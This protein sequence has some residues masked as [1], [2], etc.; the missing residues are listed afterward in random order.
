[1]KKKLMI[2][3]FVLWGCSVSSVIAYTFPTQPVE[4]PTYQFRSTSTCLSVVGESAFAPSP[5]Y[6]P[7]SSAQVSRPRR[8]GWDAPD[9]EGGLGIVDTPIGSP[10]VLVV[11]AML[12]VY[13]K[14]KNKQIYEKD[15]HSCTGS[16]ADRRVH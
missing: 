4:A 12:Y 11:M 15:S 5:A 8:S 10:W 3:L 2:L 16:D 7:S 13:Y 14:R 6:V 9:D 1:M